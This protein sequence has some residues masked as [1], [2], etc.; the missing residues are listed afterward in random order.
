MT[1]SSLTDT[2]TYIIQIKGLVQ[3]VGFRPFIYRLAKTFNLNG[4]VI[5]RNDGVLIKISATQGQLFRFKEAIFKQAPHAAIVHEITYEEIQKEEFSKFEIRKSSEVSDSITWV[6]P[7]IA[8]CKDCMNDLLSQEH[9]I[10]YPFI[11]C[12]HCGPRFSIIRDLPY[13]R[14]KTTMDIF[15]MCEI[16]TKEY[17]NVNDRRFHAQPVACN[18]CGPR[19]SLIQ[20][21]QET[22][23]LESILDEL[24]VGIQAGGIFAMKGMGGYHLTCDAFNQ[25]A[26]E[27]LRELK[28]RDGKPFAVL[29][30]SLKHARKLAEISRH[31]EKLLLSWKRPVVLLKRKS[32][33]AKAVNS[34]LDRVGILLPYMPFHF[35]LMERLTTTAIVLTSGNFS[36]EPIIISNQ[37]AIDS[38]KTKTSGVLTYNRDI[39]NRIDDS[40]VKSI[41]TKTQIIRR[42]RAYA[43]SP[44]ITELMTEG[45]FAAG[46]ELLNS[47][48]IGKGNQAIMSQYIGDL[49][50]LETLEFY[51]ESYSR[52]CNLFKFNPEIVVADMHPAYLSG[53]FAEKIA[54]EKQIKLIRVQHHHAHIASVMAD[55]GLDQKVIGLSLDGLGL[56]TDNKIWGAEVMLA[57]LISFERSFHYKYIPMPGGDKASQQPWRMALAYLYEVFGSEAY[58]L[59]L[60]MTKAIGSK[61]INTILQML[62]QKLNCPEASSAGR[63]F[64]AVAAISGICYHNSFQAEA[65]M[66]LESVIDHSEKASYS[67]RLTKSE[68]DFGPM[69]REI[70][71]DIQN[72]I[73]TSSVSAKFH[74]TQIEALTQT[75]DMLSHQH[76][77]NMVVLSGGSFQNHYLVKNITDS[78]NKKGIKVILPESVPVNDQGIALGQ[79][80]IAAK[81]RSLGLI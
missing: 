55:Q 8:V 10:A 65:P 73:P 17:M 66:L 63:L 24:S 78:L 43:P 9:R 2:T 41:G 60:P 46:A 50:N 47:F 32:G 27:K 80:A 45:I 22:N 70:Y 53:S 42:S 64:D 67:Y 13:D 76:R 57:D 72:K 69:I 54:A 6:S 37:L 11:N 75:A 15:P 56:G 23:K 71:S 21:G 61:K 40:V 28:N 33:L 52:F 31:E 1:L 34:G 29:C 59:K 49:K 18:S 7:D 20:K 30:A 38:F 58:D 39:H 3:G 25:Q 44:I 77:I 81:K 48:A 26:V 4:W 35:Q 36:D 12:P 19:Y 62:E 5:N 79:L 51:E 68:I 14:P 74:N 16:C